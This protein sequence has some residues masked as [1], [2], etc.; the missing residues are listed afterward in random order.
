MAPMSD[1]RT[2]ESRWRRC[3]SRGC[4][5]KLQLVEAS[6]TQRRSINC[7]PLPA[8]SAASVDGAIAMSKLTKVVKAPKVNWTIDV[9]KCITAVSGLLLVLHQIG[10]L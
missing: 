4:Q 9:A 6:A 1:I 2:A 7:R 5:N 3:L 10:L 8:G